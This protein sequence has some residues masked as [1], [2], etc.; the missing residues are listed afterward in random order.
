MRGAWQQVATLVAIAPGG[1]VDVVV[2]RDLVLLWRAAEGDEVRAFQGLCPHEFA[3][4]SEGAVEEMAGDCW[5]RCPRHLARFRLADG[6][7]G[8]GWA[9]APLKRYAV[10]VEKGQVL[11]PDPLAPL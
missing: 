4:L 10:R 11:L 3:R 7:C 5:L 6:A 1:L 9:L 2:G 8:P